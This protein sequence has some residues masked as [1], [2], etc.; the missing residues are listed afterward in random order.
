[1]RLL[2]GA[3]DIAAGDHIA[4]LCGRNEMPQLLSLQ[5]RHLNASLQKVAV[6][7]L[8]DIVQRTLNAVVNTADQTRSEFNTHR[9][10]RAGDRSTGR[11]ARRLLVN[12]N[13]GLIAMN[14]DDL[15]DQILLS[16]MN[17]IRHVRIAHARGYDKR[18][19]D[20]LDGTCAHWSVP[21]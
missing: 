2:H 7:H 1:M 10:S 21:F 11:E 5:R 14:F 15:T 8:H 17:H 18:S 6:R 20:F 9:H 4:R 19:G 16:Y 3:E 13:G 12:L